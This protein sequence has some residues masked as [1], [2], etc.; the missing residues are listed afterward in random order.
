MN[1]KFRPGRKN[2]VNLSCLKQLAAECFFVHML[3]DRYFGQGAPIIT[4]MAADSPFLDPL[5]LN[6]GLAAFWTDE[7]A[8]FIV[9]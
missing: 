6:I 2:E 4:A 3:L 5:F 7:D 9:D 8:L 1:R